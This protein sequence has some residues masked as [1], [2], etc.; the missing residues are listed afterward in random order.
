[1]VFHHQ[2]ISWYSLCVMIIKSGE[3]MSSF[4]GKNCKHNWKN[5][6]K[7]TWHQ[8]WMD[9]M[10]RFLSLLKLIFFS[11][12]RKTFSSPCEVHCRRF[13]GTIRWSG[14]FNRLSKS[15][16]DMKDL[17]IVLI[18]F[19]TFMYL[20]I[21]NLDCMLGL[22]CGTMSMTLTTER[23]QKE[24]HETCKKIKMNVPSCEKRQNLDWY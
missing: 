12:C 13:I 4:M 7:I 11:L 17:W 8:P 18:F 10:L 19:T 20:S 16:L 5:T 24:I 9:T 14:S 23:T 2:C 1:L 6:Q 22:H 21:E 15:C 3:Y